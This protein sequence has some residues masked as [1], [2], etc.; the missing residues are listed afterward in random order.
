MEGRKEKLWGQGE[1]SAGILYFPLKFL[2]NLKLF[3]KIK[4]TNV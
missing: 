4:L 1:E 2:V 3:F